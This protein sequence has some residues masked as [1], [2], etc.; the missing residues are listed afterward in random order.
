METIKSK[1]EFTNEFNEIYNRIKDLT[2]EE[3]EREI[4][5]MNNLIQLCMEVG[6]KDISYTRLAMN[7]IEPFLNKK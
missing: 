7:L 4:E 3:R 1:E 5:A 2:G 6:R